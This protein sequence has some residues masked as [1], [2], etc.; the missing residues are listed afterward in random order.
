MKF[1]TLVV[2]GFVVVCLIAA[3][4]Q[5][6][7]K[8]GRELS[9]LRKIFQL[10]GPWFP[11]LDGLVRKLFKEIEDKTQTIDELRKQINSQQAKI[12]N[13]Y[14]E[15]NE[16]QIEIE[17]LRDTKTDLDKPAP[18]SA[19][20]VVSPQPAGKTTPPSGKNPRPTKP[21][22][23]RFL[24]FFGWLEDD[25]TYQDMC[26]R[27]EKH[28]G[29]NQCLFC[30]KQVND[31]D[32]CLPLHSPVS[33]HRDCYE[34][35]YRELSEISSEDEARQK[36]AAEPKRISL[37][38]WVLAH[39]PTYPPDWE[40]RRKRILERDHYECQKCGESEEELHVHHKKPI[41]KG[42]I[43]TPNNLICLCW[44]CHEKTH[45]GRPITIDPN[46]TRPGIRSIFVKK[47][48]QLKQ[49]M[50]EHKTVHFHYRDQ[51]GKETDR[52][53]TPQGWPNPKEH[54][55]ALCVSGYC[56][57]RNDSR[58]FIVHR[59]SGLTINS[60]GEPQP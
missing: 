19:E 39:W 52:D 44:H 32:E 14:E 5:E 24:S 10:E 54:H 50:H 9:S 34:K 60:D 56:H 12:D 42:G 58:T 35:T 41:E 30:G 55:G 27:I 28:S 7:I 45:G 13:L 51:N 38:Y 29:E 4:I 21:E 31:E 36:F 17:N 2:I 25:P 1:E 53:F 3:H 49:A 48:E 23:E 37:F 46:P 59:M 22:P 33:I 18:A 8:R 43:H 57:L 11:P 6:F 40:F 20:P 15:M 16:L 47:M 26:N